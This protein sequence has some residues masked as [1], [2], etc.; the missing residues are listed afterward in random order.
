MK[1][2]VPDGLLG[3]AFTSTTADGREVVSGKPLTIQFPAE[4]TRAGMNAGCN[5]MGGTPIF[6]GDNLAVPQI[7]STMMACMEDGVMEQERWYGKWLTAG[8][9]WTLEGDEL[10]LTGGDVSVTFER[11]GKAESGRPAPSNGGSSSGADDPTGSSEAPQVSVIAPQPPTSSAAP[12]RP[13]R[14]GDT[15]MPPKTN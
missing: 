14:S 4:G 6:D 12:E 5:G 13:I 2:P 3:S 8:V 9:T 15:T 10:T 1:D 11:T 7:V